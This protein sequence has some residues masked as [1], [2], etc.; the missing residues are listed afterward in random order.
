MNKKS[1]SENEVNELLNKLVS[2]THSPQGRFT[3]DES[4]SLLQKKLHP[5]KYRLR[6]Y[7]YISAAAAIILIFGFSWMFYYNTQSVSI[8]TISTLA[9]IKKIKLPDGT[10][11]VLDRYSSIQF[12]EIFEEKTRDVK[13]SGEAYFEVTKNAA[14]PFIVETQ[15]VNIQVLGTH[16]NVEAY[17]D[18]PSVTTTLLEGSVAVS[19]KKQNSRLILKPNETAIYNKLSATFTHLKKVDAE[20]DIVWS[21]GILLFNSVPMQEIALTLSHKFNVKI[22]IDSAS[23][24]NHKF[25]ARFDNQENLYE[26]LDLL[27][28]IGNFSYQKVDN[29]IKIQL[30]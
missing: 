21:Q 8:K 12:P 2:S 14:K 5:S 25:T 1:L 18:D 17:K 11:V 29:K 22:E 26:I 15:S 4:F 28:S 19:N 20:K 13:L 6:P 23:L 30:K 7:Q 10:Q 16:F 27:K 9:E 24:R 3:A